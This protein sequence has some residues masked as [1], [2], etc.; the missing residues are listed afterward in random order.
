MYHTE[1]EFKFEAQ[2]EKTF[3]IQN[4]WFSTLFWIREAHIY[5]SR[6]VT[7]NYQTTFSKKN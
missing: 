3:R 4:P 5:P 2:F 7:E 1:L 6:Q